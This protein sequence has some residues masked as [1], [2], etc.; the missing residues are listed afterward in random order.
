MY[1]PGMRVVPGRAALAAPGQA[2]LPIAFVIGNFDGVHLGHQALLHAARERALAA[3]GE[4][5]V[6][7]FDPHPAKLFAPALAPPLIVSL[8]RR[9]EL[10]GEAG[11]DLVVVEPF[12]REF[13]S[14]EAPAF[15]SEVLARDLGAR[16]V[17]VGYDF[18]YGRGRKGD[19]RLLATD[20]AALGIGVTVV[21][22]VTVSGLTCSSTKVREFA[23]EGRVEGAAM[24]LG[25]PLEVTG[26]VVHGAGRGR[27][28]GIPTANVKPEGE[29][30]PKPGIY[31]GRAVI[32]AEGNRAS[33]TSAHVC[34]LSIGTNPTFKGSGALT[35]EGHLL[36]FDGDLYGRRLRLEIV[37]RLR[38]EQRFESTAALVE[39]IHADFAETRRV[40]A[41]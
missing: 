30:L 33:A 10:L 35:I 41:R 31:A 20:G 3:G 23:L 9:I 18:S 26:E 8:R 15:V 16:D 11:A 28:I 32:L 36:D 27:G 21:P 6:L 24:L 34:A 14:I 39:Q 25:R 1:S 40:M 37:H 17:V 13:A 12:T 7:T 29:L 4:V 22:P 19:T 2:R 38:D 5:G